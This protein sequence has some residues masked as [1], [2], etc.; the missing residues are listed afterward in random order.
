MQELYCTDP[1]SSTPDQRVRSF[2]VGLREPCG[3]AGRVREQL[4]R[5]KFVYVWFMFACESE[6]H[7][8]ELAVYELFTLFTWPR[9]C[10]LCY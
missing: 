5:K 3:G 4:V 10:C 7:E 1:A 6:K 9:P 8:P 2:S